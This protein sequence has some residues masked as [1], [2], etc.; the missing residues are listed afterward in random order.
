M[1]IRRAFRAVR[2]SRN[3]R[4][5]VIIA[6]GDLTLSSTGLHRL[7]WA[8]MNPTLLAYLVSLPHVLGV[9][10]ARLTCGDGLDVVQ[11]TTPRSNSVTIRRP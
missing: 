6:G 8:I 3:V 2:A 5:T 10:R 9:I 11:G 1:A 4:W 7:G